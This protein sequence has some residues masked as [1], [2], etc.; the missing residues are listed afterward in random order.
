[1]STAHI[2]KTDTEYYQAWERGL[3]TFELRKNDRDF[4]VDDHITL[5][6]VVRDNSVLGKNARA[7]PTGRFLGPFKVIYILHDYQHLG[8]KQGYCIL[9]L[10]E[11]EKT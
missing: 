10:K 9:Q 6:E 5:E 3:K 1:M 2:L 8:I 7:V 11:V 4:R